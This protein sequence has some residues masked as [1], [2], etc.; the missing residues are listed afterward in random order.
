MST[1][2]KERAFILPNGEAS[3]K[4]HWDKARG[5]LR[6]WQGFYVCPDCMFYSV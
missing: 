2:A 4:Y 1:Q 3:V 6:D 5:R